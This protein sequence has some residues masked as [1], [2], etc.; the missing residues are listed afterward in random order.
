M[1]STLTHTSTPLADLT[2][3]ILSH[4][5]VSPSLRLLHLQPIANH[6]DEPI[7]HF[8]CVAGQ[9]VMIDVDQRKDL[10][11]RMRRPMSVYRTHADGSFEIFYKVHGTGTQHMSELSVGDALNMLGPLGKPFPLELNT[12]HVL[13]I[14][15]GIGVAPL[16]F[17][18]EQATESTR[19]NAQLLYGV[20]NADEVGIEADLQATFGEGF[21]LCTDDGSAGFGGTVV[22]WLNAH[23]DAVTPSAVL[24][25][26]PWG[27][28]AAVS[29][30][31]AAHQPNTPVWASLEERMPCGTGA[32]TGCVVFRT[33]TAESS[34]EWP[35]KTCTE[36]PV[37]RANTIRWDPQS[38]LINSPSSNLCRST[39]GCSV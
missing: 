6:R 19:G 39:E 29:Q 20:R 8:A 26:G 17:W 21:Y 2:C 1:I 27:M 14:G 38:R 24:V 7:N 5:V 12:D 22:D 13:L 31:F 9:F 34:A 11:E 37:F 25:C 10:Y 16:V 3:R 4:S 35:T 36:G 28:M 15:G 33:D 23:R 30:W 18:A 32:C